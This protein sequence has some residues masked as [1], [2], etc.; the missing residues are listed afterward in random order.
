MLTDVAHVSVVSRSARLGS[1]ELCEAEGIERTAVVVVKHSRGGSV[2]FV[3]CDRCARAVRRVAAAAGGPARF[4][5]S[6]EENV[7]ANAVVTT[8]PDARVT[9]GVHEVIA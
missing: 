5:A 1:C 7:L 6:A 9:V 2:T 3:A 8:S 4:M